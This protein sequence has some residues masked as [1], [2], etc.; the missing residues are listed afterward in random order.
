MIARPCSRRPRARRVRSSRR[1]EQRDA[2][3]GDDALLEGGPRGLQRVL[4]AVLLLLHLG[5]GG[6]ADLD[7]RD[8]AGELRQALLE[9]LAVEVGVGVLDLGLELL[10]AG[11]DLLGVAGAVDDRRRVLVDDDLA[12]AAELRELRVLELEAHLL[13][14]D[15]AARED[16]D[17]LEHPLAAVAE[18][19]SL[20]RDGRERAAQLVD[21]DRRERLALDVLG[22]D[23]QR[24][25]RP[26]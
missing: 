21:D 25:A 10:D 18:A 2:A 22:D 12:G 1:G 9:L 3:A 16:G 4:D 14:D 5:L 19:G 8:A 24:A 23:Q 11:L 6:R 13:G 26:G 20:D 17:V 7:D 15:L